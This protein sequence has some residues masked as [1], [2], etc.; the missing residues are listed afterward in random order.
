MQVNTISNLVSAG[1]IAAIVIIMLVIIATSLVLFAFRHKIV[2]SFR[3]S[4]MA[5]YVQG[6]PNNND[7]IEM[8]VKNRRTENHAI[9]LKNFCQLIKDKLIPDKEE[10]AMINKMDKRTNMTKSKEEAQE[11][12][13]QSDTSPNRSA[14]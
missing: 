7:Q 4:S 10:F 8:P 12:L 6:C 3:R 2:G 9:L 5:R 13:W 11:A 1:A 14:K